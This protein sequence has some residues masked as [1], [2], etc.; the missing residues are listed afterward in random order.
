VSIRDG[1]VLDHLYVAIPE[2]DFETL[3]QLLGGRPGIV[4]NAIKSGNDA[5]EGLYARSR[6]GAYFEFLRGR[7]EGGLGIAF[8]AP[9][10]N[11]L[12][13]RRIRDE[14]SDLA[15]RS[16]TRVWADG[17]PWFDWL[18]LGDYLDVEKTRFNAWLMHYHPSHVV[19]ARRRE[20]PSIDSFVELEVAAGRK[21]EAEIERLGSWLPGTRRSQAD[22]LVLEVPDRDGGVVTVRIAFDGAGR[23]FRLRTMRWWP[24]RDT[25]PI[26]GEVGAWSLRS[27]AGQ[28]ILSYHRDG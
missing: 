24:T 7:R 15:W 9:Y 28:V 1:L 10:G 11:Y 21:L 26:E 14:L 19:P 6:T 27:E 18:S 4:R 3:S 20:Q 22:G 25:A 13:V 12:D 16:G 5:W 2:V 17:A 8:S 23:D